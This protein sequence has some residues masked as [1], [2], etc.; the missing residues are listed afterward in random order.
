ML[1]FPDLGIRP[2]MRI[3][4]HHRSRDGFAGAFLGDL[5]ADQHAAG[6]GQVN[7]MLDRPLGPIEAL[8]RRSGRAAQREDKRITTKLIAW[9]GIRAEPPV[10][11]G[12]ETGEPDPAR[13]RL[14]APT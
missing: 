8:W 1:D 3:E 14:S 6:Q 5:A 2:G 13:L 7:G 12:L 10:G 9:R 4:H 11:V